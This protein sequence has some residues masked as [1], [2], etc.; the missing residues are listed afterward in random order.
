VEALNTSRVET[1]SSLIQL[2]RILIDLGMET[3]KT[4][5]SLVP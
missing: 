4:K 5:I 2:T 1:S 3:W